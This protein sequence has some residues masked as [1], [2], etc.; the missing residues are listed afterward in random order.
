MYVQGGKKS[1]NMGEEKAEDLEDLR[2]V[3]HVPYFHLRSAKYSLDVGG[4]SK[5]FS[6]ISL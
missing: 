3:S 5:K 6:I 1:L 4:F 2:P